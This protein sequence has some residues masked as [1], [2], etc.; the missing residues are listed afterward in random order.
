M[1]S[2]LFSGHG[3]DV[4]VDVDDGT[5]SA[6]VF[7]YWLFITVQ[8][9]RSLGRECDKLVFHPDVQIESAEWNT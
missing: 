6:S 5:E 2:S 3:Y 4:N 7:A 1:L 8:V 9:T